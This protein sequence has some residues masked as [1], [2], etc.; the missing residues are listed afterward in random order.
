[1]FF[2]SLCVLFLRSLSFENTNQ[3]SRLF[4]VFIFYDIWPMDLKP[5]QLAEENTTDD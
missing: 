4:S 3:L 2:P 5:Q 1:M